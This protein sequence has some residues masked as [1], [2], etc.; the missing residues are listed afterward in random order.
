MGKADN[1]IKMSQD[2]GKL[3]PVT[4][5]ARTVLDALLRAARKAGVE[6]R[7][8]WRVTS[9]EKADSTET[10]AVGGPAGE[11]LTSR[12]IIATGGKSLPKTVKIP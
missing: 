1:N 7:Y 12:V 11:I 4:D 5:N 6:I 2:T 9:I 3:F 10:F 8:P